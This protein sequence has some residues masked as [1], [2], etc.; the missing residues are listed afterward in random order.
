MCER[1]RER[2]REI[3]HDADDVDDV[4][5]AYVAVVAA[6]DAIADVDLDAVADAAALA[7]NIAL[8]ADPIIDA[9]WGAAPPKAN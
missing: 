9:A 4:A 2:E 3:I 7:A 5:N 1:E 6:R 8:A